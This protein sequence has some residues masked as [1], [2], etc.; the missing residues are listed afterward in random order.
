MPLSSKFSWILSLSLLG[1]CSHTAHNSYKLTNGY[2]VAVGNV[3]PKTKIFLIAG[4][5]DSANFSQEIIDQQKFWLAQGYTEEEIACYY[6]PPVKKDGDDEKQFEELFSALRNCYFADPK[7]LYSHLREVAKSNPQSIYVYI[8]SHGNVPMSEISYDFKD[9]E[10]VKKMEKVMALPMWADSY[11]LEVQGYAKVGDFGIYHN[12][13]KAYLFALENP[14]KADDYLLTPRGLRS[15]LSALPE[16]TQKYVVLQGCHTGG[17]ILP[18]KKVSEEN[19][20]AGLKNTKVL[21]ASRNDRTSFGCHTG[22][23]VTIFGELYLAAL[24]KHAEGKKMTELNWQR[25]F[26]FTQKQIRER[27]MILGVS[28]E[29]LSRPQF[30][31]N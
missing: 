28:N 18:A 17:F 2:R 10:I 29:S 9:A 4:S 24:K 21:T 23:H 30:Y 15:A 25:V 8:T 5:Q 22:A 1:A 3:S 20:L 14:E 6:V 19:T 11:S 7:L 26:D 16:S 31:I 27:E 13:Y 12:V